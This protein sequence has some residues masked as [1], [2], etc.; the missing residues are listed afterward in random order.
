MAYLAALGAGLVAVPLNPVSPPRALER[1]LGVVGARAVVVG[2][3]ATGAPVRIDLARLSAVEVVVSSG[4]EGGSLTFDDLLGADPVPMVER[5]PDDLAALL[6]TSGTA[7]APRPAMLSHANLR[8]NLDQL[9]AA[10]IGLGPGDVVLGALPLFHVYGLNVALGASLHGGALVVLVERF[11]PMAALDTIATHGVTH[12]A[13]APP[14]WTAWAEL[15][16]VSPE[17]FATVRM[18]T[19][20]AAALPPATATAFARRFGIDITE[21]YGL[22]EAA[23]VVTASSLRPVTPGS[24]GVPLPGVEVRLV[25]DDG[26]DA[27]VGDPGEVYVRGPNVFA[28]YW[29]DPAATAVALTDDGWLRTGDIAVVDD[30]GCLYLVD[31]AKDLI[32]VSGFNVFPAEVEEVIAGQPGVRAAAVVGVA[33]PLTGEAVKA[34]VV[35]E[36]GATV[37]EAAVVAH[38]GERLTRYKS[39]GTVTIV[40]ELPEALGGKVLRRA[41][42]AAFPGHTG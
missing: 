41:L 16:D 1:E 9:D 12:I 24:V 37:D 28:G 23:P 18:A 6:F 2:P 30:D 11:E 35:L 21:G 4:G 27:L 33:H 13:G 34:Y 10:G 26:D 14:M 19:S 36:A 42:R 29:E 39:P 38:C 31:R 15:P 5:S 22:T 7:G 17:A 25:A 3:A 40:D 32:I 8:A 20:R